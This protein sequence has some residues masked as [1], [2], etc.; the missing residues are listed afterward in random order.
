ML[1]CNVGLTEI[2]KL[3]ISLNEPK[4]ETKTFL[5]NNKL[6]S[7]SEFVFDLNE[8]GKFKIKHES[9]V[10]P[11]GKLIK[12]NIKEEYIPGSTKIL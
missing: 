5:N 2:A 1:W 6:S 7:I 12:S 9:K 10:N 4:Q 3:N 8:Y 11:E